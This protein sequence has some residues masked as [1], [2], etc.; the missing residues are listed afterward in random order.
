MA[1]APPSSSLTSIPAL[2]A[3]SHCVQGLAPRKEE[4][5]LGDRAVVAQIRVNHAEGLAGRRA[6]VLRPAGQLSEYQDALVHV[7]DLAYRQANVIHAFR[8][9]CAQLANPLM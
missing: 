7:A 1:S 8:P 3:Q 6:R 5:D 4:A 9:H 2:P